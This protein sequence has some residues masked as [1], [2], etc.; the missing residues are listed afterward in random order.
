METQN[1]GALEIF[2]DQDFKHKAVSS[3]DVANYADSWLD[4]YIG[5][6]RVPIPPY[7][8][9]NKMPGQWTSGFG[10]PANCNLRFKFQTPGKTGTAHIYYRS[11]NC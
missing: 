10:A 4:M 2:G 5:D 3:F 11:K 9:A 1:Y 7:N 8:P 6:V